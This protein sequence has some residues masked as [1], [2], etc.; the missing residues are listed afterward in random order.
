MPLPAGTRAALPVGQQRHLF[1]NSLESLCSECLGEYT[2]WLDERRIEDDAAR[3][4]GI[5]R[6]QRRFAA[7]SAINTRRAQLR[8]FLICSL[9][10]EAA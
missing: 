3:A 7:R 5:A 2:A 10:R 9:I 1:C 6:A 4:R 8:A